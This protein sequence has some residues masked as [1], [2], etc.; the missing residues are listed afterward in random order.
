MMNSIQSE[1]LRRWDAELGSDLLAATL[2]NA[3]LE[4]TDRL[5]RALTFEEQL[6]AVER[7]ARIVTMR[8]IRKADPDYTLGGVSW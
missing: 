3:R 6:A 5:T 1:N 8:T 7:G 4:P 2:R